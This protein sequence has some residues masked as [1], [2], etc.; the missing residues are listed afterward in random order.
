MYKRQYRLTKKNDFANVY[1]NGRASFDALLGFKAADNNLKQSRFGVVVS[2]KISKRAVERNLIKR[3]IRAAIKAKL[4]E[5]RPGY[6]C[7]IKA[8]PA[9]IDKK[10]A[11][12]EKSLSRHLRKLELI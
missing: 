6:D 1:K 11:E 4:K 7:V 12:V 2:K 10:Y 9:I 5:V 3:R 8:L